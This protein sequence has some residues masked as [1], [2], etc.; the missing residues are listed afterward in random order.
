MKRNRA[1]DYEKGF[2]VALMVFAHVLAYFGDPG[3]HPEQSAIT[4]AVNSMAFSTF[5]FA[6]GRSVFLAYYSRDF[7]TAAP[8][9][10]GSALRSYLA[11]C[12]SGIANNILVQEK[13]FSLNVVRKVALLQDIP[14]MSEFLISFALVAL[15]ALAL[16]KPLQ[17]LL[18]N[19]KAYLIVTAALLLSTFIPYG[20]IHNVYLGLLIGMKKFYL[21]PVLQY[22]PWFMLGLY[23]AKYSMERKGIWIGVSAACSVVGA[24]YTALCGQPGRFPPTILWILMPAFGIVMLNLLAETMNAG[25]DK[26]IWR[27]RLMHPVESMGSNSLYYLL[28]SNLILFAMTNMNRMSDLGVSVLPYYRETAKFPFNLA[29]HTTPWALFWTVIML[30]GIGFVGSLYRKPRKG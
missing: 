22:F 15:I 28:T 3:A 13:N 2:I 11:F 9:M 10:L 30:L 25:A 14:S 29:T 7:K 12:I 4:I 5:I 6:Y 8:R 17:K 18:E 21:F 23:V 16:F 26:C 1:I 24:V 20:M 19:K 27:A